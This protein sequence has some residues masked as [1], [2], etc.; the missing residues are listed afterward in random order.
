MIFDMRLIPQQQIILIYRVINKREI[1]EIIPI[2][3]PPILASKTETDLLRLEREAFW[4]CT[5]QT[6]KIHFELM[7]NL[8]NLWKETK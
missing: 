7:W 2:E 6:Q 5:L 8:V 3:Q 1:L 4:I